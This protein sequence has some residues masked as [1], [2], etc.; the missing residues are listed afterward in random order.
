ML[1]VKELGAR[2]LLVKSDSLLVTKQ[3]TGEYQAKD[4][5]LASYL[6]YVMILKAT[7]SLF[8]LVHVPRKQ[9]SRA[10]LLSKLASLGKGGRQRLV[11]QETLMSPKIAEGGQTEGSHVEV[12]G[13]NLEKERRHRLMTQETLKVVRIT[14]YGLLWDEFLEF[15]EVN[16]TK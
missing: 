4:P 10:D 8:D 11:F 14:T 2:S 5:Y 9:N 15:L 1:L 6:M 12:L 16:I 13:V 3:V 7:F